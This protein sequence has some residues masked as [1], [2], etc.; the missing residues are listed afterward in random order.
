MKNC[1][2][3]EY[4]P[5]NELLHA[6]TGHNNGNGNLALLNQIIKLNKLQNLKMLTG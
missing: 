6:A 4:D 5:N 3:I 2:A 1:Y